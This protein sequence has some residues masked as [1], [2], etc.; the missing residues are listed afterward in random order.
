MN[1]HSTQKRLTNFG[2]IITAVAFLVTVGISELHAQQW[3]GNGNDIYNNNSGNVGVGTSSPGAKFHVASGNILLDNGT[4]FT[5]TRSDDGFGHQVFGLDANNDIILNRS[6]IVHGRPSRTVIAFGQGR[7]FDVRNH[8]N[9]VV[10]RVREDGNIA[11]GTP[12]P[13]QKLDVGGNINSSGAYLLGGEF[14]LRTSTSN[15]YVGNNAGASNALGQDNTFV[16]IGAGYSAVGNANTALGYLAGRANVDANNTFVGSE[17]GAGNINGSSNT[18]VGAG[19]GIVHEKGG[20]NTIVGADAA[21]NKVNG[22]QNTFLGQEAGHNNFVGSANVFI[23]YQAGYEEEGS[24]RLYIENSASGT[25]LIYGEFDKDILM[26][27]ARVGIDRIPDPGYQ[28]DVNGDIRCVNVTQSSDARFKQGIR[29]L[30]NSLG[31]LAK[32]QGVN[33]EF[34]R[35]KFPKQG[36][37]TRKQIGLIAQEVREVFPELVS[38]DGEGFLSV[39]YTALIPVLIEAVKELHEKQLENEALKNEHTAMLSRLDQLEALLEKS[40]MSKAA[41]AVSKSHPV[42]PAILYQNQP[43]PFSQSTSIRFELHEQVSKAVLYIYDMQGTQLMK[44]GNLS[45]ADSEV[46]IEGTSLKPGMYLYSLVVDG[47]EVDTK[48]MILTE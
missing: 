17:A 42:E 36:F 1:N 8:Q 6:S 19:A 4:H 39:N 41:V 31:Q 44:F 13:T 43:N 46:R 32:L 2:R 40:A 30:V 25:P 22:S 35:E 20:K 7:T 33:Y 37:S 34:N 9:T 47:N 14:V 24:D 38:E 45:H 21:R 3:T 18:F 12:N 11:I 27:N 10:F 26:M 15:L 16:G 48:R 5:V 23:G 29:P 28:L